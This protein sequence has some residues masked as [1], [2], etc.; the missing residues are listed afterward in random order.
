MLITME[1]HCGKLFLILE[2]GTSFKFVEVLSM[3]READSESPPG[4][5]DVY[6][7]A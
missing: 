4:L 5:S 6:G 1:D 2:R 7:G 3:L